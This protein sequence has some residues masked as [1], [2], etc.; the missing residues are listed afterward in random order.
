[1]TIPSFV[2]HP[3]AQGGQRAEADLVGVR[4]P[5]RAEF[6][7]QDVDDPIFRE[8]GQPI[9]ACVEVKRGECDL[10]EP[11]A[12]AEGGRLR[13]PVPRRTP[14]DREGRRARPGCARA[15]GL[16]RALRAAAHSGGDVAAVPRASRRVTTAVMLRFF[17]A[18]FVAATVLAILGARPAASVAKGNPTRILEGPGIARPLAIPYPDGELM[19]LVA[20]AVAVSA[21]S[22]P[23]TDSVDVWS[24]AW[25]PLLDLPADQLSVPADA[26]LAHY[27]PSTG[28]LAVRAAGG[29]RWF[30]VTG[31]P[32][33]TLDRYVRL[34]RAGVLPEQPS[35]IAAYL[36]GRR[37]FDEPVP[38][39]VDIGGRALSPIEAEAFWSFVE[40]SRESE[41]RPADLGSGTG[42]FMRGRS[43]I[44][45]VDYSSDRRVF[46]TYPDGRREIWTLLTDRGFLT[47]PREGLPAWPGFEASPELQMFIE[48]RTPP[49]R[50]VQSPTTGTWLVVL[51]GLAALASGAAFTRIV[52]RQH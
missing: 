50:H 33:A 21:P 29:T 13:S 41:L 36:A 44:W 34:A 17:A 38:I 12:Q 9:F 43:G 46:F 32:R 5:Y 49:P 18:V 24:E 19:T 3:V 35:L 30:G 1:M 8:V 31:E 2:L 10:N 15:L 48:S 7:N 42:T 11:R 27:S 28:L 4:F 22:T 47:W 39:E 52:A 6:A 20:N 51:A 23:P 40:Q 45:P 26:L 16:G 14:P 37:L 25:M